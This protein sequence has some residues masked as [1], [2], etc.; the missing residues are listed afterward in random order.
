MNFSAPNKL[1]YADAILIYP[2]DY[3][4]FDL[5]ASSLILLPSISSAEKSYGNPWKFVEKLLRDQPF[6]MQFAIKIFGLYPA[7][8]VLKTDRSY[9]YYS[10]DF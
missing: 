4:I 8:R 9:F 3:P 5:A 6:L 1:R 2:V 10:G 7:Q